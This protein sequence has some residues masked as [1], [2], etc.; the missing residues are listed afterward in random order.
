MTR[1][2]H[3]PLAAITEAALLLSGKDSNYSAEKKMELGNIVNEKT[4]EL[5]AL[6]DM[7]VEK[8]KNEG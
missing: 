6:I 3:N 1:E 2:I 4:A 7:T 5:L 8:T